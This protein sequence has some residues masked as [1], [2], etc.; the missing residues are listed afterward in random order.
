M[1]ADAI[2]AP[3]RRGEVA[4]VYLK[5][6]FRRD[7]WKYD[8]AWNPSVR[9]ARWSVVTGGFRSSAPTPATSRGRA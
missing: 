4:P 6:G 7:P 1:S 2:W 5:Q 3:A 9:S 8:Q